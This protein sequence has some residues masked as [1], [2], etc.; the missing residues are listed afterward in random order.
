MLN[1]NIKVDLHIHSKASEY[2]EADGYVD[3]SNIENI[4]V[5]LSKLQENNINLISITDHNS[6]DYALYKKIK[7]LINKEPYK[8]IN[9]NLPGV[10]FDVKLEENSKVA[11]HIIC[12]FDDSNEDSICRLQS[13]IEEVKKLEDKEDY[14]TLNEFETILYNI[15]VSVLLIAHQKVI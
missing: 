12:I 7:E 2:K 13:K 15:G 3:E 11:C 9:N 14:Y 8:D 10:E 5:L 6:F 1:R 4:D